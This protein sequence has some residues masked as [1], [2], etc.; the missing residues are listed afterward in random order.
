MRH[1]ATHIL[2]NNG[3][4]NINM[5]EVKD[6]ITRFTHFKRVLDKH[7]EDGEGRDQEGAQGEGNLEEEPQ[8]IERLHSNRRYS[9]MKL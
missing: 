5:K 1:K 8:L 3:L 7:G 6:F 9:R 2:L 4:D